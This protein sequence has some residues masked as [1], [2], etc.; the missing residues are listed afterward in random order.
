MGEA[1]E[2]LGFRQPR[3]SVCRPCGIV[4]ASEVSCILEDIEAWIRQ[5]RRFGNHSVRDIRER[6]SDRNAKLIF[7]RKRRV[8]GIIYKRK[9]SKI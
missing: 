2:R 8:N 7:I 5:C 4:D 3:H 9:Y 1:V 6:R